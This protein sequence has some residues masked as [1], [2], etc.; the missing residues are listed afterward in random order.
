MK[1]NKPQLALVLGI[2]CISIFPI[3]VRLHLTNGLI[4]AFYRMFIATL[5]L[6]PYVIIFKKF[7]LPTLKNLISAVLCGIVFATDIAVWNIAIQE[8]TATQATLL[9]NLSPL[10]LGITSFLFLKNK[11]ALNFWIGT[12]VA[13]FGMIIFMGFETI[14]Q[15]HFDT[16]FFLAVLSGILYANYLLISKN[17]LSKIEILSFMTIVLIAASL[18]LGLICWVSKETFTGF[19]TTAWLVLFVQGAVCQLTA[20]LLISYATQHLRATRISVS[21]LGQA[22][23]ASFM[24]WLFLDENINWH[25]II[26]GIFLLLGIRIT[27]YNQPLW[28]KKIK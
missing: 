3:L 16:A 17:V 26:G 14:S 9:S 19:S 13:L 2:V 25:M 24:A 22:I 8:S 18:F 6:L 4:S 5:L 23:L 27:F 28:V 11:P 1:I 10:W 15:F 21:L 20:W 12:V 7:Q